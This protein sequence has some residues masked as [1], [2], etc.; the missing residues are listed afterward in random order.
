M[1]WFWWI[2]I[3]FWLGGFAKLAE[4]SRAALKTR[5][6]RR[7]ERIEA[8]QSKQL[9]LEEAQKPPEPICGCGHHLAK[10]DKQGKCHELIEVA[11][12]W[13][14]DHKPVEY[15][16]EQC[17]CQQYVGPQPLSQIYAEPLTDL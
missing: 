7:L 14:S 10:H 2:L 5:H 1:E 11:T 15:G 12:A 9:A 16:R 17:H 3:F 8:Q 4:V 6:E 13:D